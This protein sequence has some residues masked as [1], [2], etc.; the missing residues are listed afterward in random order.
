MTILNPLSRAVGLTRILALG[1]ALIASAGCSS[2]QARDTANSIST[3]AP[4]VL[5]DVGIA[6]QV[7][8]KLLRIDAD[9]ALHV[10][11]SVHGGK[12]RLSGRVKSDAIAA[13]FAAG[14]KDVSGVTSVDTALRPDANL[15]PVSQQARDAGTI[16]AVTGDL[17]AQGGINA[18]GVRVAA[19]DGAVTLTGKVKSE[20]LRQTLVDAA[21]H[22]PGVKSVVDKIE[23]KS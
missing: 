17:I 10:A 22:S 21:K 1:A 11:V 23:V 2:E 7:E 6:A 16:A 5:R 4:Q 14:A 18:F 3:D 13:R 20:S 12:V 19:H 9:S 15:P 8:A